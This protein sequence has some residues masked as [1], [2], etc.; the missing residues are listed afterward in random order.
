MK[1]EQGKFSK[2]VGPLKISAN[3]SP[4]GLLSSSCATCFI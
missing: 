3:R 4:M 1:V 2:V